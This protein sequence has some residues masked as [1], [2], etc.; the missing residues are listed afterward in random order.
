M[1]E[2][3]RLRLFVAGSAGASEVAQQHLEVVLQAAAPGHY[4]LEI[5]DVLKNPAL[6]MAENIVV[7]PTLVCMRNRMRSIMIGDL[8]NIDRLR[9][10]I[11]R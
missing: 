3:V 11:A 6:A 8:G 4:Q 1:P 5:V 2:P 9:A 7:T 10:F